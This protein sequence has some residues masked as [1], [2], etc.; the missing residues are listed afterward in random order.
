MRKICDAKRLKSCWLTWVVVPLEDTILT[1]HIGGQL[2]LGVMESS[3]VRRDVEASCSVIQLKEVTIKA[4]LGHHFRAG[5]LVAEAEFEPTLVGDGHF[6]FRGN[7]LQFQW[8]ASV[9]ESWTYINVKSYLSFPIGLSDDSVSVFASF[10]IG[11]RTRDA[12]F[13]TTFT[14]TTLKSRLGYAKL[15]SFWYKHIHTWL[16]SLCWTKT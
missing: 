9:L 12:P 16:I 5:T 13:I 8:N 3:D 1:S 4:F 2:N 15:L 6:N 14:A 11:T 10:I 7:Q